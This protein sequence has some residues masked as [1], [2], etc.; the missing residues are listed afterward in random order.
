MKTRLNIYLSFLFFLTTTA[1]YSQINR[2]NDWKR[3]R[4]EIILQVGAAQF[5]GDLGGR[6]NIGTDYSPVDLELSLTKPA[7]SIAYRYKFFKNFNIH[8]SFN[9]LLVAGDDKLTTE[10]FRNNRNLNF[11][12]NIFELATRLELSFFSKKSGHRY[13]IAKTLGR[14]SRT[15]SYEIIGFVGVGAFYYNPKGK[16][17]VNGAWMPLRPLHTEGQGLPGG[18]KQYSNFS[19]S[20]P[21]GVA[22]SITLQKKWSLGLE[23]NYRKT[24]TD[25]IDDVSTVYYDKFQLQ[26]AYGSNSVIMSDPSKGVIPGATSPDGLGNSAQ[27]GD[28]QKDSYM[29]VQITIGHFFA[30]KKSRARLR[31]KF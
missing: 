24:F 16:N 15:Y 7:I 2:A 18:P 29:G 28:L 21:M 17:P 3:Y 12:S 14:R 5:L 13:G 31:S 23:I 22:Y 10:P 30:P 11:K 4:K 26:Q 1:I 6:N 9:Y 20:I 27:R 8:N 19:I 25:Y